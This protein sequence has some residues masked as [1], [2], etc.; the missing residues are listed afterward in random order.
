MGHSLR[1][2]GR[3][4][5][6]SAARESRHGLPVRENGHSAR[7]RG[8][9]RAVSF[10]VG[11][12]PPFLRP[13]GLSEQL[14]GRFYLWVP[15]YRAMTFINSFASALVAPLPVK[16]LLRVTVKTTF[17]SGLSTTMLPWAQ[18]H[19]PEPSALRTTR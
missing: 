19:V 4:I 10:L 18:F 11:N 17:A 16:R 12:E 1:A 3:Q 9:S 13:A 6:S 14:A 2:K 7:H 15:R 8:L 5:R